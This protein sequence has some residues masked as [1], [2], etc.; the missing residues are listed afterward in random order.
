[1]QH[2]QCL[3][4]VA[5]YQPRRAQF[6]NGEASRTARVVVEPPEPVI[7]PEPVVELEPEPLVEPEPADLAGGDDES[8]KTDA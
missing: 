8:E 1:V 3:S 4:R 7:E 5:E 6:D 2:R